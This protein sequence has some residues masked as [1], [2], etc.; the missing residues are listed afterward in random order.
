MSTAAVDRYHDLTLAPGARK[1]LLARMEQTALVPPELLLRSIKAP[2][3]LLWGEKDVL[4]P[5]SNAAD[6]AKNVPD[7][8]L[9]SFPGLGHLPH[10]EVP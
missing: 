6:Y 2:V 10:N 9:V 7:I 3:L 1:A 5:F 8:R 4:I